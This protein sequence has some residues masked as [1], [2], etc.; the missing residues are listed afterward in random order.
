M[1]K[2]R[3]EL[4]GIDIRDNWS[5]STIAADDLPKLAEIMSNEDIKFVKAG[6]NKFDPNYPYRTFRDLLVS[7][8]VFRQ[9]FLE[10]PN[11]N[12]P[13]TNSKKTKFIDKFGRMLNK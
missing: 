4:L 13:K 2:E 6:P 3:I 5:L 8:A 10:I 9:L 7:E 1:D 12:T 11:L